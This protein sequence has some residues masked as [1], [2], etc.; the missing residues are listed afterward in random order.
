MIAAHMVSHTDIIYSMNTHS[1][2]TH[3]CSKHL[4][5]LI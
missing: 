1:N 3:K 4:K 5:A 2:Y